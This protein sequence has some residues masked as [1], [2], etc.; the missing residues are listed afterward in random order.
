MSVAELRVKLSRVLRE[1]TGKGG[2]L[3]VTQRGEAR[4][5]LLSVDEY[6]ALVEQLEYLDDTLE[7]LRARERRTSG[8]EARRPLAAVVRER[9]GRGRVSR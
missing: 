4:A 8:R 9:R 1:I 7:A 2:G 6:H 3:Y 5:V